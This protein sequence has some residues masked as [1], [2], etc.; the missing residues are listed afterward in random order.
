MKKDTK[1][2]CLDCQTEIIINKDSQIGEVITCPDCG[3]DF[4]IIKTEPLEITQAP[5]I[6]EDLGQ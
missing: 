6:K 3:V 4:E 2:H 1:I 5:E